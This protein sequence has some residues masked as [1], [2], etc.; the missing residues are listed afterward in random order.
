MI[1][2]GW[3]VLQDPGARAREGAQVRS[4]AGHRARGAR[5][6][7]HA[8]QRR[9]GV[10]GGQSDRRA[11]ALQLAQGPPGAPVQVLFC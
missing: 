5:R 1:S 3:S 4:G 8:L 11:H 6:G 7:G 10:A 2:P 9:Q